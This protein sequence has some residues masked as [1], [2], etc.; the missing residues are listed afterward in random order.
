MAAAGG[1][2][3]VG[4]GAAGRIGR[5]SARQGDAV[6]RLLVAALWTLGAGVAGAGQTPQ[7]PGG[8]VAA[9]PPAARANLLPRPRVRIGDWF[10]LELIA[11]FQGDLARFDQ[12]VE[13]E[14]EEFRWRRR[15]LGIRGELWDR[16]G[17]EV[18]R[19][20]GDDAEPWRDV[21]VNVRA[22]DLLEVRGGKFK[23]PFG[24]DNLTGST[25]HDFIFRAL[26]TRTLSPG[27]GVGGMAHGETGRRRLSYAIG[28]FDGRDVPSDVLFFDDDD[29]GGDIFGTTVGGR[30]TAQPFDAVEGL[31][32]GLRNL[33][34]GANAVWSEVP[35][36]LYGFQG[37]SVFGYE[38]FA[39]VYVSG[40]RLRVGADVALF[41]GPASFKAEWLSAWDDRLG[42]GLGDIDL[43]RVFGRGW[44]VAGTWL[45]TGEEKEEDVRP[46]RPFVQRGLG[47]LEVAAR[48]ER[49]TFGST[50]DQGEPA[51]ANPRA[52]NL[53]RNRD[54]AWTFGLSWILN[55]WFKLQANA[56]RESFS[57]VDRAPI[58]GVPVHWSFV[59]RVQFAM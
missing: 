54:D 33:E 52:V 2:Y 56:I 14:D 46:A 10:T 39:P 43:P 51:F 18:E 42:Q 3:H 48:Y 6:R 13:V 44:Y 41:A 24:L 47:A 8:Q 9:E 17:F 45:L 28:V 19:E 29:Q 59:G 40:D 50:E 57:D 23:V 15:R 38:Y 21:Y 37:R 34:F 4:A 7:T 49:L 16:V 53:L 31:P 30:L 22:S 32:R 25:S 58:V 26:A 36:G 11:K 27:R 1:R 35:T 5:R 55:R 12:V 20:L